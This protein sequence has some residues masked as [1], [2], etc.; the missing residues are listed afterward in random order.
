MNE[1][2]YTIATSDV[3]IAIARITKANRRA[4]KIGQPGYTYT[5][6]TGQPMPIYENEGSTVGPRPSVPLYYVPMTILTVAGVVPKL[7]EYEVIA[8]LTQDP[9]AGVISHLFPGVDVSLAELR[10]DSTACQHCNTNRNRRTT[11]I[12]RDTDG[13]MTR[14][15][16]T[17]LEVFTGI[18]VGNFESMIRNMQAD[19]EEI[20]KTAGG[21]GDF[22]VPTE[23]VIRLAVGCV[24]LHGFVSLSRA[25][26]DLTLTRTAD[27]VRSAFQLGAAGDKARAEMLAAADDDK[28]SAT[29]A[30]GRGLAPNPDSEYITNLI[31]AI[32]P[33][34]VSWENIGIVASIVTSHDRHVEQEALAAV[35]GDS[36]YIGTV[37]KREVFSGLRVLSIKIVDGYSAYGACAISHIIKMVDADGNV[38]VWKTVRCSWSV[39]DV[40]TVKA[41]VKSHSEYQGVKETWITRA[42][43]V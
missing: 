39:D 15:G 28:V 38:I 34:L 29:L 14:V 30:Y 8:T 21:S 12:V 4:A 40:V 22:A 36:N 10:A 31:A 1:I 20:E 3:E 25:R 13:N 27:R 42:M 2:T 33:D 35:I 23:K 17:C 32:T 43:Q 7:G 24:A 26:E 5:T 37:D 19:L 41:T 18:T 11:Y 6:T 9:F 16:K